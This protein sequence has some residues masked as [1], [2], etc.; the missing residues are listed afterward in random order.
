MDSMPPEHSEHSVKRV[1]SYRQDKARILARLRRIE[2][3]VRGIQRMI[4]ED[5]YCVDVLTQL[6]SVI[7]AA[8]SIGLLLLEDHIRGCLLTAAPE[9]R[10]ML[11]Q[12]LTEA[13]ERFTQSVS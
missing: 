8:R 13:V 10:E 12:E 3:Q 7:A 11:I 6:S 9:E 1:D 2:G 4:E 5:R